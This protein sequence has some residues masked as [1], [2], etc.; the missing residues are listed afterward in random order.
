MLRSPPAYGEP[1][2]IADDIFWLRVRLPFALDHVNLWLCSDHDGWT[3]I[4]TGYG[5]AP[6]RTMWQEL[7]GRL[8]A[9]RPVR[10]VL[11][12]HFHPDHVG[13]AGWL[14]EATGAE[15][16]MS[17][18]EW[19]TGRMLALDATESAVA[20][21][22][23]CYRQAGMPDEAIVRQRSRGNTYR[24]GVGELPPAFVR[25]RAGDRIALAGSTFEVLIGE[26][27]APEQVTLY[28]EE[29]RLLIAADQILPRISPVIGVWPSQPDA[30][31]LA[32]Y[33]GSLEQYRQLP[34]DTEVLPSHGLPF[35]GLHHRLE[36]LVAHHEERL[37]ATLAACRH[38]TTAAGVLE[39]LFPRALDAH[40]TG[41]ALAETLAHLNYLLGQGMLRR[42]P[43]PNGVL[44]YRSH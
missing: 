4:D 14:C 17:R 28:C 19:L 24:R 41:F 43:G 16:W 23:R 33:L 7:R 27:H 2:A 5:D 25:L 22:E 44:L 21:T 29:R 3:V 18:T 34:E 13:Q 32:D 31:P 15:L 12:T 11:V 20:E 30:D 35:Q 6:T 39:T 36:E 42:W 10:R 26:G 8:L 37:E 9:G 40:Q 38:P 1:V